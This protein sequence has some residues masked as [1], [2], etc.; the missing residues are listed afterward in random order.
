MVIYQNTLLVIDKELKRNFQL[1]FS[2]E[3]KYHTK[4]SQKMIP[5]ETIMEISFKISVGEVTP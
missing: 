2:K 1:K 4:I 5:P 3:K